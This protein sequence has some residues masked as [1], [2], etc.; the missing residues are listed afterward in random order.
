MGARGNA[1]PTTAARYGGAPPSY[2]AS[3]TNGGAGNTTPRIS[4]AMRATMSGRYESR[5]KITLRSS[6]CFDRITSSA[7]HPLEQQSGASPSSDIALSLGSEA[8]SAV[9]V[10]LDLLEDAS[11][12]PTRRRLAI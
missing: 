3:P 12:R 10:L 5:A 11:R 4:S 6:S 9:A 7:V 8:D 2:S 1:R